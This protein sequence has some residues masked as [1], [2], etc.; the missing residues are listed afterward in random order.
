MSQNTHRSASAHYT[1]TKIIFRI[2]VAQVLPNKIMFARYPAATKSTS[3]E[4]VDLQNWF[5]Q[6][7]RSENFF[8]L[9]RALKI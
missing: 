6:C 9:Y 4:R 3:E 5:C 7:A 1:L 2:K 8:F